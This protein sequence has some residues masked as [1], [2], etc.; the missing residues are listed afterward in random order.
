MHVMNILLGIFCAGLFSLTVPFTRIAALEIAP[1]IVALLRLFVAGLICMILI[2]RDGWVPPRAIW[3]PL[4]LTSFGS[5]L[6]F[7]TLMAFAMHEVPGS[8]GAVALAALPAVT[9]A[10]A[11]LR[12]KYN[13]GGRFWLFAVLGT[14]LSFS[15]FFINSGDKLV[16]GDALLGLAVLSAAFGYVEGARLSRHHGGIRVMS[17]AV[18]LTLPFTFLILASVAFFEVGASYRTQLQSLSIDG[19]ISIA[20]LAL[21]SQ[22]GGMFLWY[23]AL[24]KGPMEKV[25]MTQLLQ[26]FFTLLSAIV[27]LQ[28]NVNP[29]AWIIALMVG[30]CVIGANRAKQNHQNLKPGTGRIGISVFRSFISS[31]HEK[32]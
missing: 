31:A 16:S 29:A 9:A 18:F 26:P 1:E 22:S 4:L 30:L 3:H 25:A 7:G 23:Y 11:C 24:A 15:F 21:V 32:N 14:L 13:P 8:H 5:V 28:E 27:L 19:W 10:Y 6:G 12:D 2:L 17:W 20:Y